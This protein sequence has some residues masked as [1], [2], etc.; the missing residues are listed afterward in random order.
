MMNEYITLMLQ[1]EKILITYVLS[2]RFAYNNP[3]YYY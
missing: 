3:S 2:G 1:L